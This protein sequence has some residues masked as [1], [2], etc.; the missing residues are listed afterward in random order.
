VLQVA[1]EPA[2]PPN[3]ITEVSRRS[4]DVGQ[5]DRALGES[6]IMSRSGALPAPIVP[7]SPTTLTVKVL[8]NTI[9][10][11]F[12]GVVVTADTLFGFAFI[13]SLTFKKLNV[14]DLISVEPASPGFPE[15][16]RIVCVCGATVVDSAFN[17]KRSF[18]VARTQVPQAV[19]GVAWI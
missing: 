19:T 1:A 16:M 4:A 3:L 7:V 9:P 10:E 11:V 14:Q 5:F 2:L 8:P 12:A 13:V 6:Q 15:K 17:K 18:G